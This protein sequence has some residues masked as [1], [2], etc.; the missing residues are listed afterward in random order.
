MKWVKT[1]LPP[2]P[3]YSFSLSLLEMFTKRLL[4]GSPVIVGHKIKQTKRSHDWRPHST[5]YK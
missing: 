5:I 4:G 1:Q 2:Y 3:L